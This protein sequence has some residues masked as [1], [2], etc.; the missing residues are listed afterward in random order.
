M[1]ENFISLPP[2]QNISHK[3][4]LVPHKSKEWHISLQALLHND[5]FAILSRRVF[6]QFLWYAAFSIMIIALVSFLEWKVMG[7][8]HKTIVVKHAVVKSFDLFPPPKYISKE[9][10]KNP[11]S[12]LCYSGIN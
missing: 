4:N 11:A 3:I 12:V 1:V 5:L 6:R 2:S 7:P 10:S 8:P 9:S